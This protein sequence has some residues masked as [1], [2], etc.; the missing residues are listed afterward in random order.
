MHADESERVLRQKLREQQVQL[1]SLGARDVLRIATDFWVSSEID[2]LRKDAG[3][4]LVAYF[5]LLSR[6]GTVFEFGI[7]RILRPLQDPE[8]P[9]EAWLPAWTLRFCISFAP[10]LETFQIKAATTTIACWEKQDA[11]KFVEVVAAT[12]QFLHCEA[13]PPKACSIKLYESSSPW[14]APEHPT[15]GYSWAIG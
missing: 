15:R 13:Q 14:G 1:K 9:Y 3:D 2:G 7:N 10:T 11:A 8:A 5:E 6:K 12:P 4:G